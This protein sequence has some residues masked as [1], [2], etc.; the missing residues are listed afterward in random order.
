MDVDPSSKH[1]SEDTPISHPDEEPPSTDVSLNSR[2]SRSQSDVLP[3]KNLVDA[4]ATG[5]SMEVNGSSVDVSEVQLAD[6]PSLSAEQP[7]STQDRSFSS[8]FP[9]Q[10]STGHESEQ[11][12]DFDRQLDPPGKKRKKVSDNAASSSTNSS[13]LTKHSTISSSS[14]SQAET[15]PKR[16]ILDQESTVPDSASADELMPSTSSNPTTTTRRLRINRNIR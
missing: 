5:S 3:T 7:L 16:S 1:S 10:V 8:A 6:G 9:E 14:P 13:S 12:E 15:V 11:Q 4:T 2:S